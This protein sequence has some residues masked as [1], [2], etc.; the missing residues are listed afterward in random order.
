MP[1]LLMVPRPVAGEWG[2]MV[3][4]CALQWGD[5]PLVRSCSFEMSIGMDS[6]GYPMDAQWMLDVTT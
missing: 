3:Y 1:Q 5:V 6:D 4:K 2:R